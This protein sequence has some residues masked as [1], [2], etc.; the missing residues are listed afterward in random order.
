MEEDFTPT[1]SLFPPGTMTPFNAQATLFRDSCFWSLLL[2]STP[3]GR[4]SDIWRSYIAQRLMWDTGT[5]LAFASPF[6]TQVGCRKPP[7][8]GYYSQYSA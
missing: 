7:R 5:F 4:V 8:G 3:H 1:S 2:P 6:V